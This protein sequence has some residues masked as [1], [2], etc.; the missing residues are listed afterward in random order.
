MGL[1]ATGESR[2]MYSGGKILKNLLFFLYTGKKM[3]YN[4]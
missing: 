3:Q 4:A 2:F 1:S